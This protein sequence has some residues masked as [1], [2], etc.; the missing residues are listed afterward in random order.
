MIYMWSEIQCNLKCNLKYSLEY[1]QSGPRK[2]IKNSKALGLEKEDDDLKGPCWTTWLWGWQNWTLSPT[3][4]LQAECISLGP[5]TPVPGPLAPVHL[6]TACS[7]KYYPER[8][9]LTKSSSIASPKL[10]LKYKASLIPHVLS[11]VTVAPPCL[12]KG[13]L[14]LWGRLPF[15]IASSQTIPYT[16]SSIFFCRKFLLFSRDSHHYEEFYFF[17]RRRRCKKWAH[18]MGSWKF[19]TIWKP[20]L[21]NLFSWSRVLLFCSLPWTPFRGCW[22]SSAVAAHDQSLQRMMASVHGKCQFVVDRKKELGMCFR[23]SG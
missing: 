10:P 13:N 2:K 3:P 9:S 6:Q 16:I 5:S 19:L 17:L 12:N 21:F 4:I 11:L 18:K 14:S 15:F 23:S 20:G 7:A 1:T 22:K 8:P